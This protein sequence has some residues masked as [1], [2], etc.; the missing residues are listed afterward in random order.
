M[1]HGGHGERVVGCRQD[2]FG[3]AP[4]QSRVCDG[5]DQGRRE[6]QCP[7]RSLGHQGLFLVLGV[8]CVV[9]FLFEFVLSGRNKG[10]TSQ[11]AFGSA[12]FVSNSIMLMQ[13]SIH[14]ILVDI[15]STP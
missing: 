4:H 10:N 3:G 15:T 12:C 14:F 5:H 6:H 9:V 11:C 1:D 7:G 13:E 8:V 2:R